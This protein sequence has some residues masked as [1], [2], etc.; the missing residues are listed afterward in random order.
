MVED[1]DPHIIEITESWVTTDISDAELGMTGY[2][3]FR[4]D[5]FSFYFGKIRTESKNTVQ[6]QFSQRRYKDMRTYL[7]KIDWNN[8]LKNKTAT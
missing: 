7:A 4:K 6:E 1:I 8:T 2:V 5:S 3:M